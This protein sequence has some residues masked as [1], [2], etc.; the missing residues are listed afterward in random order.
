[1]SRASSSNTIAVFLTIILLAPSAFFVAPQKAE[2]QWL[3]LDLPVGISTALSAIE[4]TL[5]EVNTFTSALANYAD[6]I[7]TYVLQP[8]AFVLSGNLLKALTA[9]VIKFVI[10]QSNGTGAAQF[11]TNLNKSLQ[12]LSDSQA[13]M[14]LKQISQT[15]SPFASSITS[16][17][18]TNYLQ[19]TSLAGFWAANMCTLQKSSPN[20]SAYLAGNWS[21]GGVAAWFAL[22]TESQNN[23]Y[24]LYQNTQTQL[25]NVVENAVSARL[26]E[27][28]WGQGFMSWCSVSDS[29]TQT[30]N[31]A[32]TAYQACM[33]NGGTGDTCQADFENSGGIMPLGGGI[34]PGDA[35][36]NK[37]GTLGTIQTPGS[38]IKATL[39]KVLGA[40]QDK[41]VQMGNISSQITGIL[42]N[43]ATVL[44]TVNLASNILGG[45]NGTGGLLNAGG[46]S[47]ALT[48]FAPPTRNSSGSFT[49]GYFGATNS[50]I[51][52][53]AAS[54]AASGGFSNDIITRTDAYLT[55]WHTIG[56]SADAAAN[57]VTSLINVCTTN[58]DTAR[59]Q[60]ASAGPDTKDALQAFIDA[61]T[62]QAT[63][64]QTAFTTEVLPVTTKAAGVSAEVT[65]I[66]AM[67]NKVKNEIGTNAYTADVKT[68]TTMP[69]TSSDVSDAARN[70][71]DSYALAT[72][73]T[74][75]SDKATPPGSLTITIPPAMTIVGQMNNIIANAKVL[76]DTV[77]NSNWTPGST[78]T[79]P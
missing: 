36:T 11:T 68:L 14:Y 43:I 32:T 44:N 10:G 28:S 30:Q 40:Q 50:T 8:L 47:G 56:V 5:T 46:S 22:T 76:Q 74:A 23:P 72:T 63:A 12:T 38:T 48:Q 53:A 4:N 66:L 52:Q 7:N 3:T 19:K 27:L 25:A 59:A 71:T 41:L 54:S 75:A 29:A 33:A 13:Q 49:S 39:D 78:S 73:Q 61:A 31:A 65:A 18:N 64:A 24:T 77:C 21:Q 35:C 37:D 34:N 17:L 58:A 15:N 57:A 6:Y 20:V 16:A 1:M 55:A 62:L 42:G 51:N 70:A 26:S 9:S 45:S 79:G 60:L 69:P 67:N 2:A